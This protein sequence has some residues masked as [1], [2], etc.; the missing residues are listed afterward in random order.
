V[1]IISRFRMSLFWTARFA[2][3]M[4]DASPAGAPLASLGRVATYEPIF[5]TL[6]QAPDK[7]IAPVAGAP[8]LELPWPPR[9]T[10]WFWSRYLNAN[11]IKRV[12]GSFAFWR[13]VP[14]RRAGS[15]APGLRGELPATLGG[16]PS[17]ESTSTEAWFHPHMATLAINLNVVGAMSPAEMAAVCLTLRRDRLLTAPGDAAPRKL[18][19]LAT[20][21]L[22]TVY[23]EAIG[24]ANAAALP[25]AN[26]F[27]VVTVIQGKPDEDRE[28]EPGGAVHR[29]LAQVTLWDAAKPGALDTG[30][31]SSHAETSG[32]LLFGQPR[33][34]AVWDPARFGRDDRISLSCYHRNLLLGAAQTEGLLAFARIAEDEAAAGRRPRAM[35]DCEDPVLKRLID[36]HAGEDET[37]RSTSLRRLID[38]HPLRPSVD[39]LSNRIWSAAHLPPLVAP[40]P[41][42][43]PPPPA[44][45]P[46]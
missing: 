24:E 29:A 43:P 23:L 5:N 36:L 46:P 6:L 45:A 37:Y 2:N 19:E 1:A 10:Q 22:E 7:P 42:V 30:R 44:P 18:D 4:A 25:P 40:L 35:R 28:V 26:P 3:L 15:V 16:Q 27:S 8:A 38:E 11:P 33:A 14:L 20:R 17:L 34:R 31:I 9:K 13:L 32:A 12:K 41:P 21:W 39:A